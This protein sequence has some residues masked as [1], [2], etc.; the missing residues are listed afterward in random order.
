LE[1]EGKWTPSIMPE[2]P[3][4]IRNIKANLTEVSDA[5]SNTKSEWASLGKTINETNNQTIYN[6]TLLTDHYLGLEK[7]SS[8]LGWL[9]KQVALEWGNMGKMAI[10]QIKA[11]ITELNNIPRTIV[12]T[13]YIRTVRMGVRGFQT[14]TQYVPRTGLY[15]LHQGERVIPQNQVTMGNINVTAHT[16]ANPQEIA[17]M[18]SRILNDELRRYI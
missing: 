17:Q 2:V 11:I 18:I 12:T 3:E 6:L 16:N 4:E 15:M 5:I 14:G 7:K 1:L 13:H 8:P 9:L 10:T